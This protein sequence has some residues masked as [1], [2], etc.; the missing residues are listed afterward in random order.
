M[1]VTGEQLSLY[2]EKPWEPGHG[3]PVVASLK[4]RKTI[5]KVPGVTR[6]TGG[7]TRS[8]FGFSRSPLEQF[9]Q[10]SSHPC[11]Q[12]RAVRAVGQVP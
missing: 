9:Y 2:E 3:S 10:E 7:L 8:P 5:Y 4:G 1:W 12:R 6:V 11:R